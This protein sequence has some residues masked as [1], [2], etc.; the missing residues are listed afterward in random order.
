MSAC[1]YLWMS[2][3]V[4]LWMPLRMSPWMCPWMCLWMYLPLQREGPHSFIHPQHS[5]PIHFLLSPSIIFIYLA[6]IYLPVVSICLARPS[7]EVL[8][9]VLKPI[10]GLNSITSRPGCLFIKISFRINSE[11]Y[12]SRC[13][14]VWL[15]GTERGSC[16]SPVDR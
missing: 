3:W 1:P 11:R 13:S 5:V 12:S 8:S 2:L 7:R 16:T 9:N 14:G 10:P 4:S 6:S 15:V